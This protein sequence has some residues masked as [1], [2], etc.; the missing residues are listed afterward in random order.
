[1]KQPFQLLYAP[2]QALLVSQQHYHQEE[3]KVEGALQNSVDGI[4]H[5]IT[6][7]EGKKEKLE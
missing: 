4:K 5:M 6:F 7:P 1:M 2:R 3:Q